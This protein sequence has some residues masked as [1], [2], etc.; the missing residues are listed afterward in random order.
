[1]S[2]LV[3]PQFSLKDIIRGKISIHSCALLVLS[4]ESGRNEINLSPERQLPRGKAMTGT[5]PREGPEFPAKESGR[6]MGQSELLINLAIN[7]STKMMTNDNSEGQ[8]ARRGIPWTSL[9]LT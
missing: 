5:M 3:K 6:G 2:P 9:I 4:S 1:M 7:S 8:G